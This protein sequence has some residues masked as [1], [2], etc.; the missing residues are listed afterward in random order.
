MKYPKVLPP[1]RYIIG[2]AEDT[3]FPA[4]CAEIMQTAHEWGFPKTVIDFVNQFPEDE[5]FRSRAEFETRCE[6]LE[7]LINEERTMPK[8][9]LKSSQD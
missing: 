3:H 5:I 9:L 7:M 1:I 4:N 6:E 2:L 8:E